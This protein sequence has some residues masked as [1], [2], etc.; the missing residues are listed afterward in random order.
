M[1][2]ADTCTCFRKPGRVTYPGRHVALVCRAATAALPG[3]AVARESVLQRWDAEAWTADG[4][5][6]TRTFGHEGAD[7]GEWWTS[8]QYILK[9]GGLTWVW[10]VDAGRTLALLDTWEMVEDGRLQ[11]AGDDPCAPE[12]ERK[13]GWTN[14]SGVCVLEDPPTIV[15]LRMPGLPGTLQFT[16]SATTASPAGTR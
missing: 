1:R 10:S 3:R 13:L 11:L 12:L 2:G 5:Q 6:T 15:Q 8:V 7:P 9:R 14:T 4:S 16:T